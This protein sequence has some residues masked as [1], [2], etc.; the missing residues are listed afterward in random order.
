MAASDVRIPNEMLGYP[1]DA[2]LLLVNADDFGMCHSINAATLRALQEGIV[3]STSLMV[4]CPW[5]L[6]AMQALKEHPEIPFAVHLTLIAE[7]THYRWGPITSKD[8]V[9]TLLDEAGFFYS[10]DRSREFLAQAKLAEIELEFRAQIGVVLAA[11]L[12]PTHLDWHCLY[13]GESPAIF[14]LTLALAQ[15][16]GLVVRTHDPAS[17]DKARRAGLPSS[18]H[19]V[20][21]SYSV[22]LDNKVA[23]YTHLLR[24]LPPGLSEWAVHV[25]LGDAEAQAMESTAWQ[26]RKTDFDFLISPQARDLL[27]E[28]G[29]VLLDYR[30][31]HQAATR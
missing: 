4:P 11:G 23:R 19:G 27:T 12:K 28:E 10:N 13:D 30:A 6:H 22:G 1:A 16:F 14:D 31:L 8:K 25:S 18:E 20:V 3:T 17:A 15:E 2:R 24:E 29:I 5:A 7:H 21:D 26:V 9:P